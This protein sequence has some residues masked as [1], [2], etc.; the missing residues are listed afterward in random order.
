MLEDLALHHGLQRALAALKLTAP[1]DVQ[2]QVIPQALSGQD[3]LVSAK[4]GS[5]KTLAYLIPCVQRI[6]AAEQMADAGT[7]VLILVPTR[8]LARQVEKHFAPLGKNTGLGAGVIIGGSDFRYQK[9]ILRKNPEFIIATPG[10]LV[11][12]IKIGSVD[13]NALQTLVIDEADHMLDMGFRADVLS[14]VEACAPERQ[15]LLLSATLRHS[16]VTRIAGEI[17]NDATQITVGSERSRHVHIHQQVIL[18]DDKSHKE[19]LL[20]HLLKTNA[21]IDGGQGKSTVAQAK[22]VDAETVDAETVDAETDAP[23]KE[24]PEKSPWGGQATVKVRPRQVDP[25]AED[26]ERREPLAISPV[27]GQGRKVLVFTNKRVTADQ[28]SA[29]LRYHKF[30]AGVLHGELSQEERN[31]MVSQFA[32]GKINVLVASD[33][34]ARGLDVKDIDTVVNFDFPRSVD[35]YI[36]RIGRTGRAGRQGLAISFV[37]AND[38]NLMAAIERYTE[39]AFERR[40]VKSLKAKFS[41]PKKLK[42][43]GKA[44][45]KKKKVKVQDK[46]ASRHRNTKNKGKRKSQGDGA[47]AGQ[48]KA[49]VNDGLSPLM[50]KK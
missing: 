10:R 31:F 28:L 32:E 21:G 35:D 3:L 19:K 18:S 1:T 14:I 42:S 15:T 45:G 5:G 26:A 46:S 6:L 50:K 7:L 11:E 4:T 48:G 40:T 36:H 13:L 39:S 38:W 44:A 37:S 23:V 33:V 49:P 29:L 30:R 9:S 41:G 8:E 20:V 47:G 12:L 2:A 16:G 17:L 22:T 24:S 34:A 27:A 25:E 43:N